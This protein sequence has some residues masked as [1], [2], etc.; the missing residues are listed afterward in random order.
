MRALVV[1]FFSTFGDLEVLGEVKE[2]LHRSG[3]AFD[4][5]AFSASISKEIDGAMPLDRAVASSYSHLII[6]CGPFSRGLLCRLD[7]NLDEYRH[8]VRIGI[9][10]SMIEPISE[11][12]PL[13]VVIGRDSDR[14]S[15]P[16]ISVVSNQ[17]TVPV[18]GLCFAPPQGEYG[19]RQAHDVVHEVIEQFVRTVSAARV[20]LDT[21]WPAERNSAGLR[22]PAE[23]EALCSRLDAVITTRLH[24]LVLAL[25]T[26]VPAVAVDPVNGGGKVTRQAEALGWPHVLSSETLCDASLSRALS[27]CLRVDARQLAWSCASA[28]G[29]DVERL[30]QEFERS[31]TVAPHGQP[32]GVS[33]Y[34]NSAVRRIGKRA[35]VMASRAKRAFSH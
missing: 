28:A 13:D 4:V 3:L 10:L 27:E 25:K 32:F 11:F 9:N 22:T 26:G 29:S 30:Q 17:P 1:G 31:L 5:A 6:V 21:R 33:M 24:G 18:I 2:W 20:P 23:F 14:W 7:F 19:A 16:D 34:K 12:Q 8:C 35:R 15:F